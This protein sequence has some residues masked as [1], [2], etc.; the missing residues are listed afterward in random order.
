[1][2]RTLTV[3]I[4]FAGRTQ[5]Q[6]AVKPKINDTFCLTNTGSKGTAALGYPAAVI[7][8]PC[9]NGSD[10]QSWDLDVVTGHLTSKL[11]GSC[12]AAVQGDDPLFSVEADV[13]AVSCPGGTSQ[14]GLWQFQW[15]YS[16][17]SNKLSNNGRLGTFWCAGESQYPQPAHCAETI[18]DTTGN[19][20]WVW[21]RD[22]G[23]E[24]EL[25]LVK[26]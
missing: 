3:L 25:L 17:S 14:S 8:V 16:V 5:A 6:Y 4:L 13:F 10:S 18:E 20:F 22:G 23:M 15:E 7:W 9:I 26:A 19:P 24:N 12:L 21:K 11:T 2:I 1:M